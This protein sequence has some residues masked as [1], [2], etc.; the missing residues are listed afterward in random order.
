MVTEFG[1]AVYSITLFLV[2]LLQ[3]YH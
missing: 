3:Q 1:T 2:R